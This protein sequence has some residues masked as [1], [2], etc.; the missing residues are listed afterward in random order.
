MG[1]THYWE[2][3]RILTRPQF[4]AAIEDCR[5]LCDALNI[6]LGD[7]EG[8]GQPVFTTTEICFNG[9]VGNGPWEP[10]HVPRIR[11]PRYTRDQAVG[12]WWSNF[13]KTNHQP[14]DLC[15]Q[16]C[17]IVL[18]HRFGNARFRVS[19]DGTSRDWND[20]R[21][22]CQHVLGYGIDWGEGKWAPLPPNEGKTS[23]PPLHQGNG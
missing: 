1:Y 10:F 14:Y 3:P 16:G 13:C 5:R 18:S 17:L 9:H 20:A 12:G 21:N 7:A 15:V 2:R 11:R 6:P 19:S 4:L 23:D 22:A 8:N